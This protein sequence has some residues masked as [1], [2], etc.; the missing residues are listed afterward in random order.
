MK[1]K[2]FFGLTTALL[3]SM[4]AVGGLWAQVDLPGTPFLSP[5]SQA[6]Q[7]RIRSMADNLMRADAYRDVRFDKWY[8]YTSFASTSNVSLGFATK[9]DDA[10]LGTHYTGNFWTNL[11]PNNH[12]ERT[13]SGKPFL[14]F[15]VD[16]EPSVYGANNPTN[17]VAVL[18]G[19]ADMGFR[20]AFHS[21]HQLFEANDVRT[22]KAI[23]AVPPSEDD[24]D[25]P[26]SPAGT[27][28]TYYKSYEAERGA[29]QPQIVWSMAKN[30]TKNN[31][32]RPYVGVDL[33]FDRN[34][35]K[36]DQY[37][38]ATASTSSDGNVKNSQNYFQPIL[39]AGLGGLT[40]Y[41]KDGFSAGFDLDYRLRLR[42]YDNEYSYKDGTVYKTSKISGLNANGTLSEDSWLENRIRPY[43]TGSWTKDTLALR[44]RLALPVTIT[45]AEKTTMRSNTTGALEKHG[46]YTDATTFGFV[47]QVQLAA[48]WKIVPKL[49]LNLGGLITIGNLSLATTEGKQY[50]ADNETPDSDTKVI[51]NSFTGTGAALTAGVTFNITD[52]LGLE[53]AIGTSSGLTNNDVN[54]FSTGGDGL[55]HFGNIL[56][57]LKF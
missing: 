44:F 36:V 1:N 33:L 31:G 38:D 27:D 10:Y 15:P 53:A 34:Y 29:I 21:T 41:N 28:Y 49:A 43:V 20:F 22:S 8:G 26:G 18:I 2:I 46:A 23:P 57:S 4:I 48:Q 52:N 39:T 11:Q 19:V 9:I 35:A 45:N 12:T 37:T 55:F 56:V 6:T 13:V 54:V 24:P 25:D 14:D 17:T 32:I 16:T 50:N 7:T 47:P 42:L 51:N 3:L 40:F 5:Q 30:L